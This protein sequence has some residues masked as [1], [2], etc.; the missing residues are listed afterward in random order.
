MMQRVVLVG[1]LALCRM[2]WSTSCP[3]AWN[4]GGACVIGAWTLSH[5]HHQPSS[6][7]YHAL[8]APMQRQQKQ[9]VQTA[10]H[11]LR[12]DLHPSRRRGHSSP[13]HGPQLCLEAHQR[14]SIGGRFH[15]HGA[16][17]LQSP[18]PKV[19]ED[20][21]VPKQSTA[22]GASTVATETEESKLTIRD[23]AAGGAATNMADG[24]GGG[25]KAV[26]QLPAAA[27][28][29]LQ[30]QGLRTTHLGPIRLLGQLG[31]QCHLVT[32]LQ[33]QWAQ[34]APFLEGPQGHQMG[35]LRIFQEQDF[36]ECHRWDSPE[37]RGRHHMAFRMAHPQVSLHLGHQEPLAERLLA[38]GMRRRQVSGHWSVHLQEGQ[39]ECPLWED[40]LQDC[41]CLGG[42]LGP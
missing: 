34:T 23:L 28:H 6:R 21:R 32:H 24:V 42:L 8:Q 14:W 37:V 31:V 26:V 10:P 7:R 12:Q 18:L 41:P 3:Q 27:G 19:P 30:N 36:L 33:Q 11:H 13:L 9:P 29:D 2:K 39:L 38:S 15:V 25:I 4:K 35:L 16:F 17:L 20:P 22:D 40:H 1:R 5:L